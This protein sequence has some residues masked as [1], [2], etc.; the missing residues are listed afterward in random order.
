MIQFVEFKY[1]VSYKIVVFLKYTGIKAQKDV[2]VACVILLQF[3]VFHSSPSASLL[4]L[5]F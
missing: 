3:Y 1:V 5:I 2:F 4:N